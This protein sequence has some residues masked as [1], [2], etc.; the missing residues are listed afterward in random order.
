MDKLKI[1]GK[2]KDIVTFL[3]RDDIDRSLVWD[4]EIHKEKRKRSLDSNAYFHVLCDKLRQKIGISMAR[5]KNQLIADYGQIM[6]L[7]EGVPLI[8]KTNAPEEFM[9]ELETIHTKCIKV[10][11]EHGKP[12]YFYRVYRG[13][14][15][16]NTAE[17][18]QLI[19]GT[20]SSCQEQ[21]ISTATPDEI[22]HMQA[23]WETKYNKNYHEQNEENAL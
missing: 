8:Y 10:T 12:V 11:E 17:M 20:V 2:A 21:G 16:Y 9:I 15:E 1:T 6:Y 4:L 14:H 5:C 23:L 7:E 3:M 19:K 18:A 13:S 22:A